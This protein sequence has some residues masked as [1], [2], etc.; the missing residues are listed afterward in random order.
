M[1]EKSVPLSSMTLDGG[2]MSEEPETAC[3]FIATALV[4]PLLN[5]A[6][7]ARAF[8]ELILRRLYGDSEVTKQKPLRVVDEGIAW[9]ITGSYQEPEEPPGTGAWLLR[10]RKSDCRVEELG[11]Y[12]PREIPDEIKSFFPSDARPQ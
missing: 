3:I 12:R 9:F 2:D 8:A 10:V 11:H 6:E 7:M 5:D 4:G 1:D